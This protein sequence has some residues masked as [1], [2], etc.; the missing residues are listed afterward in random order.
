LAEVVQR[1]SGKTFREFTEQRIF[2]PLGMH[3]THFHD[4]HT[5]IV[6]GRAESY[7]PRGGGHFAV[8]P[9]N[10]TA[11]GSSSLFTTVNDLAKWMA[12]FDSATVG[13]RAVLA[14]VHERGVLNSG[15]TIP[16]A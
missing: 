13:T 1:V 3:D 6:R 14:R 9:N 11:L 2:Q 16:Y 7:R 12:N 15:D 8:V 4:D 10:L 5:E